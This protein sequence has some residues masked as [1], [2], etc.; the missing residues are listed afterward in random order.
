ME[1]GSGVGVD[2]GS[3]AG[4]AVGSGVGIAVGSGV[5]VAAGVGG[6]GTS[7]STVEAS[8]GDGWVGVAAGFVGGFRLWGFHRRGPH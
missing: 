6:W 7:G 3:G 8:V 2:A 4:V 5:A 1:V